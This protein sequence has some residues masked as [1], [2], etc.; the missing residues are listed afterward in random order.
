MWMMLQQDQPD[1]YVVA[2]G[3]T[4][5]VLEFLT[6][7]LKYAELDADPKKYV[8]FDQNLVRPSEVDL[9]VGDA[10]KANTQLGWVPKVDFET[11]V[12]IMI[13]NDLRIESRG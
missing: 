1:D 8:D 12:Q 6:T 2:T 10:T 7:A 11:L 4:Y 13:E 3:K 5:S 9:L